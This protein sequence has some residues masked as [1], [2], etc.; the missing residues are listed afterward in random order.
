MTVARFRRQNNAEEHLRIIE[1]LL[2]RVEFAIAFG[3]RKAAFSKSCRITE[4]RSHSID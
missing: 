4:V 3:V 2:P 1:K